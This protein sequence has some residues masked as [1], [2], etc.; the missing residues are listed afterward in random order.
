MLT[1]QIDPQEWLDELA[2]QSTLKRPFGVTS[3]K[4]A[5]MS[6]GQRG[7]FVMAKLAQKAGKRQSGQFAR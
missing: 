2:R 7:A 4:A 5:A 3:A 6:F 1:D